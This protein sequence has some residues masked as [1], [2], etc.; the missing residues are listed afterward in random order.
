MVF[1]PLAV[2][3]TPDAMPTVVRV[4]AVLDEHREGLTGQGARESHP[5]AAAIMRSARARAPSPRA[6]KATLRDSR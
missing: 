2:D 6:S 4:A 3:A 1:A 5:N